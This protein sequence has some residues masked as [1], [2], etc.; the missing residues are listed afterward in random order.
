MFILGVDTS[1]KVASVAVLSDTLVL[2]RRNV[3]LTV[4]TSESLVG[5]IRE[6]IADSGIGF[7]D[8]GLFAV[9][10]GPG[11]FTG[12]R[13]GLGTVMGLS[14]SL[15]KPSLPVPSLAI[16]AASAREA[17]GAGSILTV[18]EAHRGDV[19]F[20]H[21]RQPQP[22]VWPAPESERILSGVEIPAMVDGPALF[23]GDALERWRETWRAALGDD[24]HE[25]DAALS[26]RRGEMAAL[27]GY[28]SFQSG[29][30]G[31]AAELRPRYVRAAAPEERRLGRAIT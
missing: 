28:Q 16:L 4:T 29:S 24:F 12:L 18:L 2:C 19:Y 22:G 1:T 8:V 10:C 15:E 26:D 3:G 5:I 13:V 9:A 30:A 31:T 21:H 17:A 11:S 6:A 20:Q 7:A 27:L 23:I 14:W 25:A